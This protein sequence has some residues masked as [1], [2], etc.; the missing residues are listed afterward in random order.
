MALSCVDRCLLKLDPVFEAK[1]LS[2]PRWSRRSGRMGACS[3]DL[4]LCPMLRSDP[5]NGS[6]LIHFRMHRRSTL[7]PKTK[8]VRSTGERKIVTHFGSASFIFIGFVAICGNS[9]II[10]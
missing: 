2:I 3:S 6:S 5:Q 4:K 1:A 10:L 8:I 9:I 7:R